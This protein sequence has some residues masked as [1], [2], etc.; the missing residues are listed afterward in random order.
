MK[1]HLLQLSL[2]MLLLSSCIPIR[3]A[4]YG[5]QKLE[6]T[7]R[8]NNVCKTLKGKTVIYAV[9]VESKYTDPWTTFDINST[10]DSIHVAAAWLEEEARQSGVTLTVD[11]DYHQ[12]EQN[13]IPISGKLSGKTLSA[14]LQRGGVRHVDQWANKVGKIAL[15]TFPKD[16]SSVT[17][18]KVRPKDRERLIARLRDKHGTDNIALVYFINNYFADEKSVALHCASDTEAEYAVV[19]FKEPSIIAQE[20]L[21]LF[22]AWDLNGP[23]YYYNR[24][25]ARQ[26]NKVRK[27]FPRDLMTSSNKNL[28]SLEIGLFTQYLIGWEEQLEDKHLRFAYGNRHYLANQ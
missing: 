16:T 17:N 10:L 4:F 7:T 15:K 1:K 19:S 11:V 28:D 14:T 8:E 12:T 3:Y 18:T 24:R 23:Q 5:G 2:M 20:F 25:S 22:G 21:R 27:E 9:F 13:V 26:I 6:V